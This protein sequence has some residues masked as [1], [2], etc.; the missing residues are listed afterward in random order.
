MDTLKI[1]YGFDPSATLERVDDQA[2]KNEDE[3]DGDFHGSVE[4][5]TGIDR[6]G[7]DSKRESVTASK[8]SIGEGHNPNLKNN[9]LVLLAEQEYKRK[10]GSRQTGA[11]ADAAI[12]IKKHPFS[13][14]QGEFLSPETVAHI[15]TVW[16]DSGI[17]YCFSRANEFQLMDSCKYFMTDLD[18][19]TL[20]TYVPNEQ[21][22]LNCRIMTTSISETK[23]S[24][25][26]VT[27]KIYDVGG[28]RSERKKWAPYFDDV[29]A[30]IY[31]A[32][33][34]SYDQVCFEDNST[35]RILESLNLFSSICNHPMFK[36]TSMIL[37]LNKIDLFKSK[38]ETSPVANYFPSYTEYFASRFLALNKYPERKIYVHFTWA[39]DTKQTKKVLDTVNKIILNSNLEN[40][41]I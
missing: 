5:Q 40:A 11:V 7:S 17:Q 3:A 30:I 14:I 9:P 36:K 25:K 29:N 27:V 18:R 6:N 23:I 12:A 22:I 4:S 39:T 16:N 15:K 38:I 33:I 31:L 37:F 35:N 24:I 28:Q 19:I 32:A 20:K 13:I 21:D 41:N 8:H 26:S 34:S 2:A 1:P 10:G